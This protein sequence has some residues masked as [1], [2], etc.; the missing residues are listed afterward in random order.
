M[1]RLQKSYKNNQR[2]M[3]AICKVDYGQ[4]EYNRTY[5]YYY[6]YENNMK[7]YYVNGEYGNTEFTKRQFESIFTF[8]ENNT[9]KN[10][11]N[12]NC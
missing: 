11:T 6:S 2:Y 12:F 1:K 7:K 5:N 8:S 4:F 10:K 9:N 3:R